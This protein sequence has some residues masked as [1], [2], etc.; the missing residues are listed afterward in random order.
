MSKYAKAI[1]AVVPGP[2]LAWINSYIAIFN[3]SIL[4]R[5]YSE[6]TLNVT[7]AALGTVVTIVL[8]QVFWKTQPRDLVRGSILSLSSAAIAFL[9]IIVLRGQLRQALP[10][11][12]VDI[13][14]YIWDIAYVLMLILIV[15]AILLAIMSYLNRPS[16]RTGGSSGSRTGGRRTRPS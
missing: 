12:E 5:Q 13:L 6:T 16:R 3:G 2:I 8:A 11:K 15:V 7:A 14:Y 9:I 1:V 4:V 10:E